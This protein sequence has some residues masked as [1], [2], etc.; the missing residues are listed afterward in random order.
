[1]SR[2]VEA[3]SFEKPKESFDIVLKR[4]KRGQVLDDEVANYF[5]E[6]A[7]LEEKYAHDLMRLSKKHSLSGDK[8]FVGAFSEVWDQ[9]LGATNELA[10]LHMVY[11]KEVV[12]T[13]ERPVRGRSHTDT[14]WSKLKQYEADFGR[15]TKDYDEKVI[16]HLKAVAKAK[17]KNGSD[18]LDKKVTDALAALE[19]AKD[20]WV[21]QAIQSF[22]RFQL[23]DEGRLTFLKEIISKSADLDARH[24][25][26]RTAISDGI[27]ASA[28]SFD[29]ANDT[30]NFCSLKGNKTGDDV[31]YQ[32]TVN[33][34]S[35]STA[36][37]RKNSVVIPPERASVASSAMATSQKPNVDEE[38]YTIPPPQPNVP[39]DAPAASAL[40]EEDDTSSATGNQR[41]KVDIRKEAIV[42]NP[43]EATRILRQFQGAL[44][45]TINRSSKRMSRR[46][47]LSDAGQQTQTT[48]GSMES[49]DMVRKRM[50]I[51]MG[52]SNGILLGGSDEVPSLPTMPTLQPT[53][54]SNSALA[55]GSVTPAA[56]TLP[57]PIAA[58]MVETLNVL[59]KGNAVE[60]LLLM[61]EVSLS[62]PRATADVASNSGSFVLGIEN[63]DQLAQV[64]LNETFARVTD[65][66]KPNEVT[67]DLGALRQSATSLVPILKYQVRIDDPSE[68][69]PLYV[70]PVWKCDATQTSLLL[71]Y[72]RN[73]SVRSNIP[74]S[75]VS[76]LVHVEGGGEIG[77]V[78]MK[79]TGLWNS[80]RKAILWKVGSIEGTVDNDTATPEPSKI[81]AR[82]ETTEPC[83][84]GTVIVR[85][86]SN[87]RLLSAC[88]LTVV[89]KD[90]AQPV[91]ELKD[92]SRSVVAG[93]YGA[94]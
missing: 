40:D 7:I 38:G 75:D 51:H 49:A 67:L 46:M 25:G 43:D 6:R 64:V 82:L 73:P 50:T 57:V 85:F 56:N 69:T 52:P 88:N 28:M 10:G 76:F 94:A 70:H 35:S 8:D 53:K 74:L 59:I 19:A 48:P 71:A 23:M 32:Y 79:P 20:Q 89:S 21:P 93:K 81:L 90:S 22:E 2:F 60:R 41:I 77:Q 39:W 58:S 37:S 66:S 72:Q 12:E 26:A 44:P 11:A 86:T 92:I 18:K 45:S 33:D 15:S 42:E 61:G 62:L 65:P 84:P 63:Y 36:T 68:F 83:Q 80:D 24:G 78:Q 16:K 34:V 54:I 17:K 3:F 31:G 29:V 47:S 87:S 1:M 55:S 13:L 5:K 14:D 30:A 91:V 9:L 4:L 27:L